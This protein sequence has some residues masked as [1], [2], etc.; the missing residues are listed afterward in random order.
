MTLKNVR[1]PGTHI[2]SYIRD[3]CN[4]NSG[5]GNREKENIMGYLR[6]F[7]GPKTTKEKENLER[8]NYS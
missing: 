1:F 6:V 7:M 4:G 5:H 8:K 2:P 3:T